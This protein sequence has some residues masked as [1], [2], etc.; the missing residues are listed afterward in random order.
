MSNLFLFCIREYF[1]KQFIL[2][3][4]NKIV[5]SYYFY[6]VLQ[7]FRRQLRVKVYWKCFYIFL[8][9]KQTFV[10]CFFRKWSKINEN[11]KECWK[12]KVVS[13]HYLCLCMCLLRTAFQIVIQA[14]V[15]K[16]TQMIS[17]FHFRFKSSLRVYDFC[18]G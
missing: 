18:H 9:I 13:S 4:M 1:L 6:F 10:T 14:T 17:L 12:R 16:I 2:I 5:N 11:G 8:C 3:I 7:W 15:D